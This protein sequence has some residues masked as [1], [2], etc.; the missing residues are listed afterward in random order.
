MNFY[1]IYTKAVKTNEENKLLHIVAAQK[2]SGVF[3]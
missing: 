3:Y 1:N 2:K